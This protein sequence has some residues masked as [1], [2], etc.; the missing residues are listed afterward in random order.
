M[1]A[2]R[3]QCVSI[4]SLSTFLSVPITAL[5]TEDSDRSAM[6]CSR[7]WQAR[8]MSDHFPPALA[9]GTVCV[10]SRPSMNTDWPRVLTS[11][12]A[13]EGTDNTLRNATSSQD[14]GPGLTEPTGRGAEGAAGRRPGEWLPWRTGA[15]MWSGKEA[16]AGTHREKCGRWETERRETAQ[17]DERQHKETRD[18]TRHG[19]REPQGMGSSGSAEELKAGC[20]K[21]KSKLSFSGG[22]GGARR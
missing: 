4:K 20:G 5:G 17:R 21:E 12:G 19:G 22:Q 10:Q 1:P 15:G 8:T 14:P 18:S 6:V 2:F 13:Q 11:T 3:V 9:P 7:T 16:P